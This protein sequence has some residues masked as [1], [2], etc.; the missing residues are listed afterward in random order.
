M[1][2]ISL[3]KGIVKEY[4]VQNI[5]V[6][7]TGYRLFY[8]INRTKL[9]ATGRYMLRN[10]PT[11]RNISSL[12]GKMLHILFVYAIIGQA[13]LKPFRVLH[14]G[15]GINSSIS[16]AFECLSLCSRATHP[17]NMSNP[18]PPPSR[19]YGM[20]NHVVYDV[21]IK[22]DEGDQDENGLRGTSRFKDDF[23]AF[24]NKGL[25]FR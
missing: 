7:E 19:R 22:G 6:L 1:V 20:F 14:L 16:A 21:F 11:V 9:C 2:L 23:E 8:A 25:E 4:I 5:P 15:E 18:R 3:H 10:I 17:S 12:K 24:S 13:T